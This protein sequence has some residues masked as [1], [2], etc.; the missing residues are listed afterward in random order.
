M[1][2]VLGVDADRIWK[3]ALTF[4]ILSAVNET[5]FEI[6]LLHPVD[7]LA[8]R[9]VNLDQL[10]RSDDTYLRQAFAA[11]EIARRFIDELLHHGNHREDLDRL[12]HTSSLAWHHGIMRGRQP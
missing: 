3:R 12:T 9:I 6:R 10:Q 2:F 5:R 8:S 11:V 7:C 1:R 4:S